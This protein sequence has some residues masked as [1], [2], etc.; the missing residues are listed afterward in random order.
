MDV[1]DPESFF[2]ELDN[3]LADKAV[4]KPMLVLVPKPDA[5]G[6]ANEETVM[7]ELGLGE[8]IAKVRYCIVRLRSLVR[9]PRPVHL[10]SVFYTAQR[11]RRRSVKFATFW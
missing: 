8:A 10:F 2:S 11:I 1:I 5:S 6:I 4:S 7:Q 3:I 9:S